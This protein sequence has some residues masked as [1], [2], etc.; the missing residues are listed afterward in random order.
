MVKALY[1]AIL[2]MLLAWLSLLPSCTRP[3][4]LPPLPPL[5]SP[6]ATPSCG[7]TDLGS[8]LCAASATG[9]TIIRDL[10]AWN[11]FAS[12]TTC[13]GST[14]PPVPDFSAQMVLVYS[15]EVGQESFNYSTSVG[16]ACLYSDRLEVDMRT[17][18]QLA[19]MAPTVAGPCFCKN[20]AVAVPATTLP[21]HFNYCW[22]TM[23]L[24]TLL[25]SG[26]TMTI[27]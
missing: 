20:R 16:S 24:N 22:D 7:L 14:A 2:F 1:S 8:V 6:T 17:V 5:P 19:I 11:A 23:N 26:C 21:V 27:H 3:L 13:A 10:A 25:S 4:P 15:S 12:A 18:H 9:V